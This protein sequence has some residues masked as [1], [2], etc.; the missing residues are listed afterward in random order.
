MEMA[1]IQGNQIKIRSSQW[2]LIQ[3]DLYLYKGIIFGDRHT[4]TYTQRKPCEHENRDQTEASTSLMRG[5]EQI[6]PSPGSEGNVNAD[7][8][9][10]DI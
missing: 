5:L 6:L 9:N 10:I 4:H 2:D 7:V 3:F 1:S 8:L